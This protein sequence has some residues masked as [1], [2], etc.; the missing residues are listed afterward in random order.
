MVDRDRDLEGLDVPLERAS[1]R[2]GRAHDR[3][4]AMYSAGVLPDS[5][6]VARALA[7]KRVQA[8]AAPA[9]P[10]ALGGCVLTPSARIDPGWV[11]IDGDH[12]AEV[13]DA[14]PEG[15]LRLETDGVIL[16]GLID[17]HGHPDYNVLPPWEPPRLYPNRYEWREDPLFETVVKEAFH[18]YMDLPSLQHE[19]ARYAEFRAIVGGTTAVQGATEHNPLASPHLVRHVDLAPFGK[20]N[21]AAL[22]RP[23]EEPA[24]LRTWLRTAIEAGKITAFYAHVAEGT[25]AKSRDEFDDFVAEG[26]L[27]PATIIIH[28]TALTPDQLEQVRDAGA[29]LVWS[30]QSNL[31]LY[32]GTTRAARARQLGIPLSVGADWLPSGSV[33][34]LAEIQV[35]RRI[36]GRQHDRVS[37]RDLLLMVTSGAAEIADLAADIGQLSPG[38]RAD[39]V[40]LERRHDDPYEAVCVAGRGSVGLVAVDGKLVYGRDEWFEELAA[41]GPTEKIWAWGRWMRLVVAAH[42][43]DAGF[44]AFLESLSDIR[45]ALIARFPRLGP[46]FA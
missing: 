25:D 16:P 23:L 30:P 19:A 46:I 8:G 32:G 20:A 18:K 10:W 24:S 45:A 12:I 44:P 33:S 26:L 40:V 9:E 41:E 36:L 3:F 21:A 11:V 13:L 43:P 42:Q 6:V 2:E 35:A 17:L 14:K 37:A 5:A 39:L 34:L 22:I 31:R 38:R 4:E 28:G 15:L 29:K 7:E 27:S 1:A